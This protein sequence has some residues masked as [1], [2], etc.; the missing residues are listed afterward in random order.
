[1]SKSLKSRKINIGMD[2]AEMIGLGRYLEKHGYQNRTDI[3]L[4]HLKRVTELCKKYGYKPMMWSDMFFKLA[5]SGSYYDGTGLPSEV[6]GRIP[7]EITLVYWDYYNTDPGVVSNNLDK[8][9]LSGRPV[10]FAGGVWRWK[11]Y[12]PMIGFSL[13]SSRVILEQCNNKGV[14]CICHSLGR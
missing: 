7:E 14:Q 11:G 8:H 13:L 4:N 5:A 10:I 9:I 2:E 12:A 1:M 3:M 6:T